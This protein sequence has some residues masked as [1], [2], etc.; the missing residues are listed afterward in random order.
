MQD[1]R[2]P[3]TRVEPS[4]HRRDFLGLSGL[5]FAGLA[6]PFGRTIAA[7]SLLEPADTA[8]RR[9]LAALLLHASLRV[10]GTSP[11]VHPV[12]SPPGL[13]GR[14]EVVVLTAQLQAQERAVA[15]A[16]EHE[17]RAVLALRGVVVVRHPGPDHLARVGQAVGF[18]GVR[19]HVRHSTVSR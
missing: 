3:P 14:V 15:G 6:L 13:V 2:P 18:R 19:R 17:D 1:A 12:P 7:E 5:A 16:G 9:L 8:R 4:V 10:P 11:D